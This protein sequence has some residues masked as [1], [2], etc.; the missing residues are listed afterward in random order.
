MNNS[1]DMKLIPTVKKDKNYQINNERPDNYLDE[2][3]IYERLC[4]QNGSQV[5]SKE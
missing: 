3:E 5:K 2:R 4:R 1:T